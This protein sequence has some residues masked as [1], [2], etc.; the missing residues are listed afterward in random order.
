MERLGVFHRE[1]QLEGVL[2]MADTR[3]SE[4]ELRRGAEFRC[5][6]GDWWTVQVLR[7]IERLPTALNSRNYV[8]LL[9][10]WRIRWSLGAEDK[11]TWRVLAFHSE[12]RAMRDIREAVVSELFS[13]FIVATQRAEELVSA[14]KAGFAVTPTPKP[15]S[16]S[17]PAVFATAKQAEE[18]VSGITPPGWRRD[19]HE[20][21]LL[22][23]W[24]GT[25]WSGHQ[26]APPTLSRRG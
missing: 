9:A 4:R 17:Q 13:D 5:P 15:V 1:L 21:A 12:R 6:G 24:D 20:P 25:T 26:M 18:V 22:R 3:Q 2:R 23:Y 16:G 11:K 8:F 14:L 7:G 10:Y 19:P